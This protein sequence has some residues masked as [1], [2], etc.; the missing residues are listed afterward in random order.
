MQLL[1]EAF[2]DPDRV[3]TAEQKMREIKLM[4][5]QFSQYY[6]K[7]QVIAADLDWNPSA[8]GNALRMGLS[9]EMQD[10]FTYSDK[11]GHLPAFVMVCQ[12]QDNQIRQWRAEKAEQ[13][14]AGGIGLASPRPPPPLKVP[15]MAPAGTVGGYSGHVPMDLNAGRR[16]NSGEER[17]KM[18]ADGM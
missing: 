17:A 10:S 14:K 8:L 15:E 6:A 3:A 16:R 13:N 1:E 18:F 12:K 2:G 7:F 11:P 9:K 5:C 4:N